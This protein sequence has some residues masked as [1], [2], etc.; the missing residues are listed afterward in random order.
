MTPD[1]W[2]DEYRSAVASYS[3]TERVQACGHT[4]RGRNGVC[5]HCGDREH[6]E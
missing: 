5:V 6:A 1:E 2:N 4:I 3:D